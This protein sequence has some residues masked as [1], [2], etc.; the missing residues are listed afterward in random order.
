MLPIAAAARRRRFRGLLLPQA[1]SREAAVVEGLEFYPVRSLSEAV[2]AINNPHP[3]ALAA[4]P[5]SRID[6]AGARR[7]R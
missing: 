3:V 4:E 2:Q 1:N 7:L 5:R 6:R